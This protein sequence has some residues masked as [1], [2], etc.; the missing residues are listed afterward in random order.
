MFEE[1]SFQELLRKAKRKKENEKERKRE[2]ARLEDVSGHLLV[3]A[4]DE[5][6][7]DA[8]G[9]R[10]VFAILEERRTFHLHVGEDVFGPPEHRVVPAPRQ[11]RAR[12]SSMSLG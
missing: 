6:D 8:G 5:A 3:G 10:D 11:L 4:L 2:K 12:K 9:A 1:I 7:A